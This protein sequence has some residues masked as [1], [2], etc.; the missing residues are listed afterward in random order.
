MVVDYNHNFMANNIYSRSESTVPM[1]REVIETTTTTTSGYRTARKIIILL[2]VIQIILPSPYPN[3]EGFVSPRPTQNEPKFPSVPTRPGLSEQ[4]LQSNQRVTQPELNWCDITRF[5]Q[6]I[7][8][9]II[10]AAEVVNSYHCLKWPWIKI[11][12]YF[13]ITSIPLCFGCYNSSILLAA[14]NGLVIMGIV[15]FTRSQTT[16]TT[17]RYRDSPTP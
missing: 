17:T 12:S 14:Q 4:P 6:V 10:I 8:G 5:T 1:T 9:V 15:F 11:G 7:G 3:C 16:E 13:V 2:A